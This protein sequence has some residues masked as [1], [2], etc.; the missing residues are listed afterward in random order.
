LAL[1]AQADGQVPVWVMPS[2][3]CCAVVVVSGACVGANKQDQ[4][5]L[6][7]FM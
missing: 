4:V 2:C 1:G 3:W 7:R 6:D 5:A